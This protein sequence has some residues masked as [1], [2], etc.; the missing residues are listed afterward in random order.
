MGNTNGKKTLEKREEELVKVELLMLKGTQNNSVIAKKIGCS[1]NTAG[2]YVKA[3]QARWRS[4][5]SD[6][7]GK[8]RAELI[9]KSRKVEGALWETFKDADNS[10]AKV[11]ALNAIIEVQKF[12]A[13]LAGITKIMNQQ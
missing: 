7:F 8:M 4:L 1:A 10:N 11:G 3:V 12:Q 2:E 13:W 6:D 9:E 5:K